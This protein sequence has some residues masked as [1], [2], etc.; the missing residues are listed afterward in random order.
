MSFHMR[1]LSVLNYAHG[2]TLW[3]YRTRDTAAEAVAPDY[4]HDAPFNVRDQDMMVISASDGG[5]MMVVGRD[6]EGRVTLA[7]MLNMGSV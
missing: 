5:C 4:F 6:A 2:F 1:N 7:P 3:H